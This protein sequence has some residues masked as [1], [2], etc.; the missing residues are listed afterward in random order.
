MSTQRVPWQVKFALI[1]LIWGSSFLLIKLG[2][3]AFEPMQVGAGRVLTGGVTIALVVAATRTRLPRA[4]RVWAHLQVSSFFVCTLPFLLFPLGETRVSSALAG[5]GN[6]TTPLATVVAT[7]LLVPHER[8]SR[9]KLLAVLAGFVGVVVIAEPWQLTER[10]DPVGFAIIVAAASSY[11]LA[12]TY[13]KRFLHTADLGGLALPAAQVLTAAGQMVLVVLGWWLLNRDRVPL[14]WSPVGSGS[15]A[16]A[17]LSVLALG[18]I[19][20]GFAYVL[21]FDIYRAVGQQIGSTVT[22]V[23]PIVAVLLGVL[24][25]GESLRPAQLV[26]FAIVLASAVVIGRPDRKPAL[27][28]SAPE[29]APG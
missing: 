28:P 22:Y 1:C 13:I 16:A 14:P 24:L 15:V 10:P 20:T 25:L 9:R 19:G 5:I 27:S 17:V 18:A 12:W 11:G 23:I 6:A 7:L 4:R 29:G 26:G 8:L 21:Q 2:I 3:G